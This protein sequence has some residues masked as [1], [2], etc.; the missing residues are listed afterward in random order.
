MQNQFAITVTPPKT[1]DAEPLADHCL[2]EPLEKEEGAGGVRDL[3]EDVCEFCCQSL[4]DERFIGHPV[5]FFRCTI[6]FLAGGR[7]VTGEETHS[8]RFPSIVWQVRDHRTGHSKWGW[9]EIGP[10]ALRPCP[11]SPCLLKSE[12]KR[13][14]VGEIAHPT[15][16]GIFQ[17]AGCR[18]EPSGK[19]VSALAERLPAMGG[20]I[21]ERCFSPHRTGDPRS[22]LTGS[23]NWQW[24]LSLYRMLISPRLSR[25]LPV[26]IPKHVHHPSPRPNPH[27]CRRQHLQPRPERVLHLHPS[28]RAPTRLDSRW[29]YRPYSGPLLR[30]H[31]GFV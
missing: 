26:L 25:S 16:R 1:V 20:S 12:Q 22:T 7:K 15:T 4:L 5:T 2:P 27:L 13:D 28:L 8:R 14:K 19:R 23:Q 24:L 11:S 31:R 29:P 18:S 10:D 17:E 3:E 21:I 30:W 9:R 6:S